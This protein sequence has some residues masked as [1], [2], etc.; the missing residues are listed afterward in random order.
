MGAQTELEGLRSRCKS[1][2]DNAWEGR[3]PGVA[4]PTVM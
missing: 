1:L 2:G 3:V 4:Q